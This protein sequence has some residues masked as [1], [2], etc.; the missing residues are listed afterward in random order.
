[1]RRDV[2]EGSVLLPAAGVPVDGKVQYVVVVMGVGDGERHFLRAGSRGRSLTGRERQGRIVRVWLE[3]HG[4]TSLVCGV[5]GLAK[6]MLDGELGRL[7]GASSPCAGPAAM[8]RE[9]FRAR[10][11]PMEMLWWPMLPEALPEPLAA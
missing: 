10:G 6:A 1:M 5:L 11:P 3:L 9:S 8:D 2:G 7:C 4:V